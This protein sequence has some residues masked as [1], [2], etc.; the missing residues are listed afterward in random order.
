MPGYWHVSQAAPGDAKKTKVIR[1]GKN[2]EIYRFF[3]LTGKA[4]K[5]AS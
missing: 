1:T 5:R 3:W 2:K 4:E